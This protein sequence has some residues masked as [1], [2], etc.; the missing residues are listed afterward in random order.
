MGTAAARTA[1]LFKACSAPNFRWGD[2]GLF[3]LIFLM[4]FSA[5]ALCGK[6]AYASVFFS[7]GFCCP[8]SWVI[9]SCNFGRA[10]LG[11]SLKKQNEALD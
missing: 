1:P 5:L 9:Q 7:F 10:E 3:A 6:S 8:F 4:G 2:E 11:L